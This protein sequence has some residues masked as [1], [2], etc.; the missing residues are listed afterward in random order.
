L[1]AWTTVDD[2]ALALIARHERVTVPAVVDT[3]RRSWG[4]AGRAK[5][6]KPYFSDTAIAEVLR[7]LVALGFLDAEAVDLPSPGSNQP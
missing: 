2:A 4:R 6:E 7:H 5:L 3:I 1:E